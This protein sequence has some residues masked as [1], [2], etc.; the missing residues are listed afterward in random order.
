[1]ATVLELRVAIVGV[2]GLALSIALGQR[3]IATD[4][5][6]QAH[7]LAANGTRQ[8]ARLGLLDE[9]LSFA[10]EPTELIYRDGRTGVRIAAHPVRLGGAYRRAIL[11][12][13][14][15][16]RAAHPE[17]EPGSRAPASQGGFGF[18]RAN[19]DSSPTTPPRAS[20]SRRFEDSA[21]PR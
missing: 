9:I 13:A 18:T 7:G 16:R 1:M 19:C 21:N 4:I 6:E 20:L 12:R 14:P 17:H 10:T 5:F 11:R 15:R 8:L 2:G 3:G